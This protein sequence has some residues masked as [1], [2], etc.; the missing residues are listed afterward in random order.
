LAEQ[1]LI[2]K[3]DA[4][5]MTAP[6][7]HSLR[8]LNSVHRGKHEN[9]KAMICVVETQRDSIQ[10]EHNE[11]VWPAFGCRGGRIALWGDLECSSRQG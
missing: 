6:A 7:V 9:R 1:Q 10:S 5:I 3:A 2:N 4:T 8:Y 11:S